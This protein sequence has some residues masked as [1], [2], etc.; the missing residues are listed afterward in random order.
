MY[1]YACRVLSTL[2]KPVCFEFHQ[3]LHQQVCFSQYPLPL[4]VAWLPPSNPKLNRP[5][6][7]KLLLELQWVHCRGVTYSPDMCNSQGSPEIAVAVLEREEACIPW[8]NHST[9]KCLFG[10]AKVEWP[11]RQLT[12]VSK[13]W[14]NPDPAD[15]LSAMLGSSWLP[16]CASWHQGKNKHKRSFVILL[17][18]LNSNK[19]FNLKTTTDEEIPSLFWHLNFLALSLRSCNT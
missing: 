5:W 15:L 9:Q 3:N 16:G 19:G 18:K 14:A 6:N 17:Y 1:A 4:S 8:R 11:W 12:P 13:A 7:Y 10:D 2:T